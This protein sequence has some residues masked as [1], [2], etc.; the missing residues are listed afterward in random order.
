M[1]SVLGRDPA[2]NEDGL[3]DRFKDQLLIVLLKRLG[4][5]PLQIPIAEIDQT[6]IDMATFSL[7]GDNFVVGLLK[8]C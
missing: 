2:I 7:V 6:E 8:K 4:G 5:G 3:V 1:K